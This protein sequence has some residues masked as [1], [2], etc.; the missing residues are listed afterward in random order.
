MA[1]GQSHSGQVGLV[2]DLGPGGHLA[3]GPEGPL[4][5]G[6]GQLGEVELTIVHLLKQEVVHGE[7]EESV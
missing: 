1:V 3:A 6:A 4:A 2:V 5:A 7:V